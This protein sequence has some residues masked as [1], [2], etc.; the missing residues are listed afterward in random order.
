MNKDTYL[1]FENANFWAD[2]SFVDFPD[3]YL[4]A[5]ADRASQALA[6]MNELEKGAIANPDEGRMVGHYWLISRHNHVDQFQ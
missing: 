1:A 2:F 4:D 5:M 6:S 3:E